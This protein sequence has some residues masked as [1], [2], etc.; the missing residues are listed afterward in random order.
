[1]V[2]PVTWALQWTPISNVLLEATIIA[3]DVAA[4]AM[5]PAVQQAVVLAASDRKHAALMRM[6]L[7]LCS[8]LQEKEESKGRF[9]TAMTQELRTPLDGILGLLD[10]LLTTY[11]GDLNKKVYSAVCTVRDTGMRFKHLL[12]TILD[13]STIQERKLRMNFEPVCL[14]KIVQDVAVLI[15]PLMRNGTSLSMHVP[16]DLPTVDADATRLSQVLFNLLGNAAKFTDHGEVILTA[17]IDMGVMLRIEIKD[18][19]APRRFI[20]ACEANFNSA[21][22]FTV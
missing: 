15:E 12:A 6:S 17:S 14:S 16:R 10:S 2:F 22:F 13:A 11:G 20:A 4:K 1:L 7:E 8:D 5:M 18:S 3:S 21:L 19:G 9:F